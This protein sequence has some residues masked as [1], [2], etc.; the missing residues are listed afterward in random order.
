[1]VDATAWLRVE[2]WLSFD[3]F[4]TGQSS[5]AFWRTRT[6]AIDKHPPTNWL[7]CQ[8]C[9]CRYFHSLGMHADS[10]ERSD[11]VV[12][13]AEKYFHYETCA[14]GASPSKQLKRHNGADAAATANSCSLGQTVTADAFELLKPSSA[15]ATESGLHPGSYDVGEIVLQ[16]HRTLV[17]ERITIALHFVIGHCCRRL[18]GIKLNDGL[19]ERSV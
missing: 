3:L 15:T 2:W 5:E 7:C 10:I 12:T 13:I 16:R 14:S 17:V 11:C 4:R 19:F 9:W 18:H 6:I 8:R 1:M